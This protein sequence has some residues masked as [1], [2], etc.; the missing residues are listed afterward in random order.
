M[1]KQRDIPL[2]ITSSIDKMA[3][4]TEQQNASME[5]ISKVSESLTNIAEELKVLVSS[6]KIEKKLNKTMKTKK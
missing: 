2:L 3:S 1:L 4:V 6:F 5:D